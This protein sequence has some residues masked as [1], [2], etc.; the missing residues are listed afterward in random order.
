MAK[1]C[2]CP[3]YA[4][5]NYNK[6][7]EHYNKS[8]IPTHWQLAYLDLNKFE[9]ERFLH[10]AGFCNECGGKM[11]TGKSL[12]YN[13][14]GKDLVSEIWKAYHSYRPFGYALKERGSWYYSEDKLPD[15]EQIDT[16]IK[17]FKQQ[18]REY[19]MQTL[20][21][22]FSKKLEL[23]DDWIEANKNIIQLNE[24]GYDGSL[25][26]IPLEY[27]IA[28]R[29]F[30][31]NALI[32]LLYEDN[33]EGE[34]VDAAEMEKH[35]RHGGMFGI[36]KADFIKYLKQHGL[37]ND[38]QGDNEMDDIQKVEKWREEHKELIECRK[39]FD[40][41]EGK[42][43]IDEYRINVE[44]W[45]QD[46]INKYG[47]ECLKTVLAA[48]INSRDGDLRFNDT[49][50]KWAKDIPILKMPFD[51]HIEYW[52]EY[53]S[54]NHSVILN[55]VAEKVINTRVE[56]TN[57]ILVEPDKQPRVYTIDSTRSIDKKVS[58]NFST[59]TFDADDKNI[60]ILYDYQGES[61]E[62][63]INRS[64]D[65]TS[66][67]GDIIIANT[68]NNKC[69]ITTFSS[70]Q[71]EKYIK[72][73]ENKVVECPKFNVFDNSYCLPDGKNDDYTGKYL[74]LNPNKLSPA[75]KSE[76]N[77]IYKATGGFGCDPN[78]RGRKVFATCVSDGE[79]STWYRE[80]FLGIANYDLLPEWAKD[81]I[82]EMEQSEQSVKNEDME[83]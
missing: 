71:I 14:S 16:F 22:I 31:E 50:R 9:N 19:V 44:N 26:M 35:N 34:A 5:E 4:S 51:T 64:I 24:Y 23:L 2:K 56:I 72:M 54:N 1:W 18:D 13:L 17:L 11:R 10:I 77:Q 36:E 6:N 65:G 60:C 28:K 79:K 20:E 48:T 46:V 70:E 73:F 76:E 68:I 21:E 58:S 55:G 83:L 57:A 63:P 33:T 75:Y 7:L 61:K 43:R 32:Y 29:M 69:S 47:I 12:P 42:Y 80:D 74:I 45:T 27:S 49:A 41:L 15:D 59:F 66:F 78:S 53:V 82:D 39:Y 67:Y 40:G 8:F 25:G 37:Y 81:K 3:D 62:L 52:Y 30:N 38:S